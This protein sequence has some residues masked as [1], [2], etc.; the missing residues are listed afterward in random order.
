MTCKQL[1][2]ALKDFN[3]PKALLFFDP[4]D[5]DGGLYEIRGV[6]H[7]GSD[8]RVVLSSDRSMRRL[9][10]TTARVLA[11]ILGLLQDALEVVYDPF[12]EDG[13]VLPITSVHLLQRHDLDRRGFKDAPAPALMLSSWIAVGP[14]DDLSDAFDL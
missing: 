2:K 3:Q 5:T 13:A 12:K 4:P 7:D 11:D 14:R 9:P 6:R 8:M 10:P 1:S